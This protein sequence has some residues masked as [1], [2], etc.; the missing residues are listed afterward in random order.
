MMYGSN[1]YF[2]RVNLTTGNISREEVNPAFYRKYYGGRGVIAALLL[3]ELAPGTDAL[4]PENKVIFAT[5]ILTGNPIPGSGRHSIGAKSPVTGGYGDGEAGGFWGAEL[6]RAGYDALIV[7]GRAAHPVYLS[8]K[9]DTVTIKD[10]RHLWG[11]STGDVQ[12][13]LTQAEGKVRIA[14]IG[15]AGENLVKYACVVHDLEHFVGRC[16]IGAVMGSKNLRAVTVSGSKTPA[17]H[18]PDAVKDLT[19][20]MAQHYQTLA[21]NIYENGTLMVLP[22]L[23]AAGGLPTR[24]FTQGQFEEAEKFFPQTVRDAYMTERSGCYACPV[25]CGIKVRGGGPY[26]VDARYKGPEYETV[27]AFGSNLGISDLEVI[28]K[29][30]ELCNAYGLDSIATG[31]CI[32]FATEAYEKGLISTGETHGRQLAFGDAVCLDVIHDIALRKG[33]GE[34]LAEGT[35]SAAAQWGEATLPLAVQIKGQEMPLHEARLKQGLGLGYALSPTGAD[36]THNLHDTL[37]VK[38]TPG[39]DELRALGYTAS[40]LPASTLNAKKA[41][42]FH[43]ASFSRYLADCLVTCFFIPW[44]T[45]QLQ[46]LIQAVTGWNTTTAEMM[47]VSERSIVNARLFNLREGFGVK[48]DE[49]CPRFLEPF[50]EG[51]LKGVAILQEDFLEARSAYYQLMGWDEAGVPTPGSLAKLGLL[52]EETCDYQRSKADA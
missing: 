22:P 1:G 20:F 43:Y 14:Q 21:S 32:S 49:L 6:K 26:K 27:A 37:Y 19:R 12:E 51:P 38:E 16:G 47:A 2:L 52:E 23:N 7:E 35:R 5:G 46:Q 30:N 34:V 8:I 41:R 15:P 39:F 48:D 10:A 11:Q 33:V 4:G 25:R 36:H 42:L 50:E 31:M 24:N 45:N 40:P 28:Q 29:A 18:D 13:L 17:V 3:K 9:N 44:T